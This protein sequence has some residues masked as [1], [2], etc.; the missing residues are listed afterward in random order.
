VADD[1][2]ASTRFDPTADRSVSVSIVET[3]ERVTNRA[4]DLPPLGEQIDTDAVDALFS[5]HLGIAPEPDVR[6]SFLYE[7]WQVTVSG[8]GEIVVGPG[9]GREIASD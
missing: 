4:D 9:P 7:E 5:T 8:T 1:V 2:L 6:L 3:I